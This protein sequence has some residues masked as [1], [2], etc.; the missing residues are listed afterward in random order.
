MAV[1]RDIDHSTRI[2]GALTVSQPSTFSQNL[3]ILGN[4]RTGGIADIESAINSKLNS[5]GG[6]LSGNLTITNNLTVQ[7]EITGIDLSDYYT[8]ENLQTNGQASVHWGN[9][10]NIP[11]YDNY[12]AWILKANTEATGRSM[13]S[14]SILDIKGG[15]ATTVSRLN[16][17]VTITSTDNDTT[18]SAGSGLSIAGTVLSV[19]ARNTTDLS[20]GLMGEVGVGEE[21]IYVKL[22]SDGKTAAPGNHSHSSLHSPGSDNQNIFTS[23]TVNKAGASAE[24][25]G[26]GILNVESQ[27]TDLTFIAGSNVT[28]LHNEA[29]RVVKISSTDTNTTYSAGNGLSLSGTVFSGKAGSG[30]SVDSTGIVNADK[31]SSQHIF[32][33]IAGVS[34]TTNNDTL[35]FTG[36]GITISSENK[37]IKFL[38]TDSQHTSF[39]TLSGTNIFTAS[40][41]AVKIRPSVD[42]SVQ[43]NNKAIT[44]NVNT[45]YIDTGS[46]DAESLTVKSDTNGTV[47]YEHGTDYTVD[48]FSGQIT[49]KEDGAINFG[50]TVYID[51]R[52][53]VGLFSI[54]NPM[55]TETYFNIDNLGNIYGKSI[56]VNLSSTSTSQGGMVDGDFVIEGNFLAKGNVTLG[57]ATTDNVAVKGPLTMYNGS[58][59]KFSINENGQVSLGDVPWARISLVP[60]ASTSTEGIVKLT[61]STSSTSTSLAATGS[62]VKAAYDLANEKEGAIPGGTTS[63]YWRGDKTWQTLNKSV[64]GLGNVDNTSD[65]VKNV[66]SATKLTNPATITLSGD[67][68]GSVNF[69]G[70]GNVSLSVTV[71]DDLH[72]HT[73]SNVDGLQ[74]ALNGK[75]SSSGTATNSEKLD[76]I[77]SES[78]LRSDTNDQTSAGVKTW[79]GGGISGYEGSGATLQVNGFIRTGTIYLHEGNAPVGNDLPLGNVGGVLVWNGSTIWTA[80]NDGVNSGLNSD[81][82]DDQQGSYYLDWNN[83]TNKPDPVITLTGG[84]TGS[85]TMTNLGNVSIST[86]VGDNSHNHTNLTG[87]T[88]LS[89]NSESTDYA[90]IKT[91]VS[92]NSTYFDFELTDDLAQSD[93][94]RWR[95]TP[96]GGSVFNAMVLNPVS[97]GNADLTVSGKVIADSFSGNASS[98]SRWST[99][100]TITLGGD[101]TGSVSLDGS[102]NV[103]LSATVKDDSHSHIISNV[104]GLQ[105]ALDGK[106]STGHT[107]AYLPLSGGIITDVLTVSKSTQIPLIL[108]SGGSDL[109]GGI[110]IQFKSYP[111]QTGYLLGN[112]KDGSSQGAY[113]SFHFGSSEPKTNLILDGSGDII[114]GTNVVW[115][116]GNLT[117]SNFL[118]KTG[119]TIS[120]NLTVFGTLSA[121]VITT[122]NTNMVLNLNADKVDGL[123]GKD[124]F[125]G[126]INTV[127]YGVLTG[128]EVSGLE[129]Q[130]GISISSG[131]L[132]I[133]DY[134]MYTYTAQSAITSGF[135]PS[136]YHIVFIAGKTEDQYTLGNV[137]IISAANQSTAEGTFASLSNPIKLATIPA[138]NKSTIANSDIIC[139]RKFIPILV[140]KDQPEN[141]GI[142][143]SDYENTVVSSSS[144]ST[145]DRVLVTKNGDD[146]K[147]T[148]KSIPASNG[149]VKSVE[150]STDTIS[151]KENSST[152][153]ITREQVETW[154]NAGGK[155]HIHFYNAPHSGAATGAGDREYI[156]LDNYSPLSSKTRV[157]KNGLRLRVNT[158][159]SSWDN[160]YWQSGNNITFSDHVIY[161]SSNDAD[162]DIIIVDFDL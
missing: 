146:T 135:T 36:D 109:G 160:D 102:N 148:V 90:A 33:S 12:G 131:K 59:A 20:G 40:S 104:D 83:T 51:Y 142:L 93:Q 49:R 54:V 67:A 101:L 155:K 60:T 99:A 47:N 106:S 82:L 85:G 75:L 46:L 9:L 5:S 34:A 26:Q 57:D 147:L 74:D 121:G 44:F 95:F 87:I 65:S 110:G 78:F 138:Y 63:Q 107:H 125:N 58:T 130:E 157:Y 41:G 38:H 17:S 81:L 61:S 124:I 3:D 62:A 134:G 159:S 156:I 39:P 80:E 28:L 122:A 117:P 113:Y 68:S 89:F 2:N 143:R 98:A 144:H 133:K 115:H 70:S 127:G 1:Y 22:G 10:T 72:A 27:S 120:N 112:H 118:P 96:S 153:S 116:A 92:G 6:T 103:T 24:G 64:I 52:R 29:D 88:S 91:T 21:G 149:T 73:I 30:I 13:S 114:A 23:L 141:V 145:V 158:S 45:K 42:E 50:Q 86:V 18:Y 97:G 32:K 139:T 11:A 128:C 19:D 48:Y 126:I 108:D 16:G 129:T 77:S 151:F 8:K 4:L 111:S 132:Y 69:D 14:G 162:D 31:G 55:D 56:T 137:G 71:K 15:G 94:W 79:L 161:G 84:V 105:S 119:G 154:D 25:T 37:D 152:V 53:T 35:T 7:G 100:R 43:I 66:L 150:I 123:D 136:N 76:N 140:D